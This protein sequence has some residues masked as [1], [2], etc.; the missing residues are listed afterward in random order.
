MTTTKKL[1]ES[2]MRTI[3][4]LAS[5]EEASPAELQDARDLGNEMIEAFATNTLLIPW[6]RRVKITTVPGQPTYDVELDP[7]QDSNWWGAVAMEHATLVDASV[8]HPLRVPDDEIW[9]RARTPATGRP[10]MARFT[11]E[12]NKPKLEV[13]P[14]PDAAYTIELKVLAPMSKLPHLLH[15]ISLPPGY[16]RFL[17]LALA[18]ELAPSYGA[19][20]DQVLALQYADSRAGIV[21]TN[22]AGRART[23]RIDPALT[24]G[25]GYSI[26]EGP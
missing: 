17:R 18:I 14:T 2:A 25:G 5:G 19:E 16:V 8:S 4:V 3:K 23:A 12:N 13:K 11:T 9:R 21:R 7:L 22:A 15:E 1:I 24:R 20:V 26:I 10:S 6:P